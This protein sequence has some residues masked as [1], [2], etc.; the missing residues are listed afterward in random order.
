MRKITQSETR[1]LPLFA[2]QFITEIRVR[3]VPHL[4]VALEWTLCPSSFTNV[5]Q[6]VVLEGVHIW[7]GGLP[8]LRPS[9]LA[10]L[11][12]RLQSRA[13]LRHDLAGVLGQ[14]LGARSN[15]HGQKER[16]LNGLSTKVGTTAGRLIL[17]K[18]L[19]LDLGAFFLNAISL[20][21]GARAVLDIKPALHAY[22]NN[23]RRN[24][25]AAAVLLASSTVPTPPVYACAP[26]TKESATQSPQSLDESVCAG[27][28][29]FPTLCPFCTKLRICAHRSNHSSAQL[30]G[31]IPPTT[32]FRISA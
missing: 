26:D 32:C 12:C 2:F 10:P 1:P 23:R 18:R 21:L 17:V 29:R 14:D 20:C 4:H 7:S 24:W 13:S 30:M 31:A 6:D 28:H 25:P 15:T 11:S 27:T 16:F 22:I 9:L 3:S 5:C 19:L 8:H